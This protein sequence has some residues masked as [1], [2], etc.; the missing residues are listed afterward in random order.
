ME[1]KKLLKNLIITFMIYAFLLVFNIWVSKVV[2]VSY[3]SEIN[4]LLASVNQIYTYIALLEAGI[5][6]ATITALYAPLARKDQEETNRV[7]SASILYYRSV[8]K[9]YLAC[10]VV[11]SFVWP[12]FLDTTIDYWTIVGVILI[13]GVSNAL[14]FYYVSAT[15]NYLVASGRNYANAYIHMAITMLTYIAKIFVCLL[16]ANVLLISASLLIINAI[17]CAIYAIYKRIK[18][19]ELNFHVLADKSVL[20]QK[21]SFLVHEIIGVIFSST[22]LILISIL[23]DLKM[24]SV[25][26]VYSMVVSAIS[27]IIGQIFNSTKYILGDA[28]HKV[29]YHRVHDSFNTVY[30]VVTFALYTITY[31]L[32][33]PFI[34][35]YTQGVHDVEYTVKFLP[36][37]FVLI[38]L[39]SACR[40]VDTV[41]IKNALH[42]KQTINRALIEASINLFFSIL[43]LKLIGIQGVLLGTVLALLYRTNDM[44]LYANKKILNR[45]PWREYKLYICNLIIFS[46]FVLLN[47]QLPIRVNNY[48]DLVVS[49]VIVAIL[50]AVGYVFLNGLMFRRDIKKAVTI[51]KTEKN[52]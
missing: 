25:Y 42:S 22:D 24:A 6:T 8:L 51:F 2:L 9:W 29:N 48:F 50:V 39:L 52:S 30:I 36:L 44:I 40:N 49:A 17:K 18:F 14:T 5:G 43:L 34:S 33:P 27:S 26:A 32:L 47:V 11:V 21:N 31:I 3:G 35:I 41:L 46:A 37:L 15:T 1:K 7:C 23:C 38:Q 12:F 10:A 28:Y 45:S 4:G 13:Q 20:K 19:K 16:G